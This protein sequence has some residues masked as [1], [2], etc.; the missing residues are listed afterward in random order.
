MIIT[1][2]QLI[3][4]YKENGIFSNKV[5]PLKGAF[6]LNRIKK[7]IEKD[8]TFYQEK[9]KEILEKY[10]QRDEAGNIKFSDDGEQILIKEGLITECSKELEDLNSMEIEIDNYDFNIEEL[11]D[12]DCTPEELEILMPFLS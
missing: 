4:F 8:F 1:M 9:F 5:L 2:N 3:K 6:K 12:I 11:G 10:A 7:D